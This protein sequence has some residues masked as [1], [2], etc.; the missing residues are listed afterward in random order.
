MNLKNLEDN[1][2]YLSDV[3]ENT[4]IWHNEIKK[5]IVGFEK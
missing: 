2:K 3:Q 1:N 4:N 5:K